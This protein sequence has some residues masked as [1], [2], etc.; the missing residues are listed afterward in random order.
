MIVLLSAAF[1][2]ASVMGSVDF[3]MKRKTTKPSP[4]DDGNGNMVVVPPE[5]HYLLIQPLGRKKLF[6]EATWNSVRG[7][8]LKW[9]DGNK[10]Q[11]MGAFKKKNLCLYFKG[12]KNS[13]FSVKSCV[14]M[15]GGTQAMQI[16]CAANKSIGKFQDVGT[17][18]KLLPETPHGVVGEPLFTT[19]DDKS[20][21]AVD[22]KDEAPDSPKD[23]IYLFDGQNR[24]GSVEWYNAQ[25]AADQAKLFR[26]S[27]LVGATNKY[28]VVRMKPDPPVDDPMTPNTDESDPAKEGNKR[29]NKYEWERNVSDKIASSALFQWNKNRQIEVVWPTDARIDGK[30]ICLEMGKKGKMGAFPYKVQKCDRTVDRGTFGCAANNLFGMAWNAKRYTEADAAGDL[31]KK[32]FHE[33]KLDT[34]SWNGQDICHYQS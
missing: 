34:L 4:V 32:A 9:Q 21:C 1:G 17:Q 2:V 31:D 10:I 28:L 19:Q 12:N 33:D 14:G 5:Y 18:S 29:I 20:I 3:V 6:G 24:Q 30:P 11:V 26:I 8:P 23:L 7:T 22:H 15:F 27:K 25:D 13:P 16:G